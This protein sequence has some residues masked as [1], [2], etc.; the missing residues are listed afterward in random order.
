MLE[1]TDVLRES[2]HTILRISNP[3]TPDDKHR[4][5]R[6]ASRLHDSYLSFLPYVNRNYIHPPYGDLHPITQL[7]QHLQTYHVKLNS[8]LYDDP[9]RLPRQ[10]LRFQEHFNSSRVEACHA[11]LN[12]ALQMTERACSSQV[13]MPS[14]RLLYEELLS[15]ATHLPYL[16]IDNNPSNDYLSLST[17]TDDITLECPDTGCSEDLG[18]FLIE[19]RFPSNSKP[20]YQTIALEPNPPADD[21]IITHPHVSGD[22]PCLGDMSSTLRRCLYSGYLVESFAILDTCLNTYTPHGA[23]RSLDTWHSAGH[24]DVCGNTISSEDSLYYCDHC[25]TVLCSDCSFYCESCIRDF[26]EE[27]ILTCGFCGEYVCRSCSSPCEVC[28]DTLCENCLSS[29]SNCG[30]TLCENCKTDEHLCPDCQEELDDR[31]REEEEDATSQ[32]EDEVEDETEEGANQTN[33]AV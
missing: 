27:H 24:C 14:H 4:L 12:E 10:V 33:Q 18:P 13:P 32:E 16:E 25:G 5:S 17:D 30:R 11:L 28:G 23:Y 22:I 21:S 8:L 15:L 6:L 26:C 20:R 9:L 3:L 2:K 7:Y 1:I 19:I 31:R 29:C